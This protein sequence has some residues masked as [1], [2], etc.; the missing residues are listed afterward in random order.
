MQI[1]LIE[2]GSLT[3]RLQRAVRVTC[4]EEGK[5]AELTVENPEVE[6][7]TDVLDSLVE[8][9]MHLLRNAVVH[10]IESPDTRRLLGK[11]EKGN[12]IVRVANE[13]T[14]VVLRVSDDGRGIAGSLLKEKAVSAGLLGRS[15]STASSTIS[16]RCPVS[17]MHSR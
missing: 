9:L 8:P 6:L 7:D 16:S 14:H 13:E 15:F 17:V 2:F 3:T 4:E 10:G 11:A 1:R 12:V 5:R